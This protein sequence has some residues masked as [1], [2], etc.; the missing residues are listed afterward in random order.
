[1]DKLETLILYER[2]NPLSQVISRTFGVIVTMVM[3]NYKR[4][5]DSIVEIKGYENGEYILD[6]KFKREVQDD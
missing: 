1:M 5:L 3:E 2:N 4:K 6:F